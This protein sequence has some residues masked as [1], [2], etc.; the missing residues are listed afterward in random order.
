MQFE[1]GLDGGGAVVAQALDA[2][3]DPT[4][5]AVLDHLDGLIERL[6]AIREGGIHPDAVEELGGGDGGRR[7]G[8]RGRQRQS[9]QCRQGHAGPGQQ[10]TNTAPTGAELRLWFHREYP[11]DI[12]DALRH[13]R[14]ITIMHRLRGRQA[15]SDDSAHT[16]QLL[17]IPHLSS[18][19]NGIGRRQQANPTQ[20]AGSPTACAARTGQRVPA[21]PESQHGR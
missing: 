10:P 19:P 12:R 17:P 3:P 6:T 8:A 1:V 15:V 9:N 20:A 11:F 5:A 2:A 14:A 13:D 21:C 16:G 7:G 4:K 18:S